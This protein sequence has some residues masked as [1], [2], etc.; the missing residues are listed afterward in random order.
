MYPFDSTLI[1]LVEGVG[2]GTAKGSPLVYFLYNL[3]V[4]PKIY[5]GLKFYFF[6]KFDLFFAVSALFHDQVLL[7][8]TYSVEIMNISLIVIVVFEPRRFKKNFYIDFSNNKFPIGIIGF[9]GIINIFYYIWGIR[10]IH[11]NI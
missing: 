7:L 1:R 4:S 2:E 8:C 3:L 6:S 9:L 5:L 11:K 10:F